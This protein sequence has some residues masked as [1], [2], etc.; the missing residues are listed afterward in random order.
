MTEQRIVVEDFVMLGNTVPQ[1]DGRGRTTVCCAGYSKGLN[2]FLRIYPAA[3]VKVP[4]R[5]SLSRIA[6]V[7]N[8]NDTR[9]ESWKIDADR[10]P[11]V[12]DKINQA[13]E[14]HDARVDATE[15]DKRFRMRVSRTI[16]ELNTARRS[17]GL[18][19]VAGGTATIDWGDRTAEVSDDQQEFPFMPSGPKGDQYTGTVPYISFA[20]G[21][22]HH[23]LQLRARDVGVYMSKHGDRDEL[24]SRLHLDKDRTLLIG[25]LS[26]NRRN[27]WLVIGVLRGVPAEDVAAPTSQLSLQVA[28]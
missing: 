28:S 18:I 14:I 13:F 22:A 12:H 4:R 17:L 10:R 24:Y 6:L 1:L 27:V 26:G 2:Q 8:V 9:E 19:N 23:R 20:A 15:F 25:N 21:G 11:E 3:A 16:G 7:R 5:W